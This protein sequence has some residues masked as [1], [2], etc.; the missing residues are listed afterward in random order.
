MPSR[1]TISVAMCTYNGA[2]Y[3]REQLESMAKQTRLPDELVVCDDRSKDAT[4]EIVQEFT[5]K[6]PF[7]VHL[8]INEVNLGAASKGITHAFER[9]VSLCK[10]EI[11]VPSDQD[12]IWMPEK[13]ERMAG[14]LEQDETIGAVFSDARLIHADGRPKGVRMSDTTGFGPAEQAK[15]ARGEGL[16]LALSGTK[17]YGCTLMFRARLLPKILPVPEHWWFD[18]WV[19]CVATV[20]EKWSFIPEEL[21]CYRIH[22]GQNSVSAH[23]PTF[24]QRI[25]QWRASARQYWK[26]NGPQ[27][28]DLQEKLAAEIDP[29]FAKDLAYLQGRSDLLRFRA[30]LSDGPVS[31]RLQVLAK[32]PDYFRYF[33]GWRSLAKDLSA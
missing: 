33:N 5:A 13:L 17:A 32:A 6:A 8:H 16:P 15:L 18:A 3:L 22:A 1:T 20:Y 31:R 7:P 10:G 29:R 30:E 19:S 28:A 2:E 11:I 27:L 24:K 21:I 4:V 23:L 12:D 26:D 9:A 25:E 14:L